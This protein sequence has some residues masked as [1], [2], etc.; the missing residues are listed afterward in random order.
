VG[1]AER[2]RNRTQKKK[3]KTKEGSGLTSRLFWTRI[4]SRFVGDQDAREKCGEDSERVE[5][6]PKG[7]EDSDKGLRQKKAGI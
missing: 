1:G 6:A 2:V 7:K 5:S 3:K 4:G